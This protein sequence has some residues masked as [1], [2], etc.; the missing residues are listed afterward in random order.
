M[1]QVKE[2]HVPYR[3]AEW[4]PCDTESTSLA[5]LAS[6]ARTARAN[7]AEDHLRIFG[8]EGSV[9]HGAAAAEDWHN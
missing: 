2:D 3:V 8:S 5:R 9:F 6:R 7:L 4:F 1:N